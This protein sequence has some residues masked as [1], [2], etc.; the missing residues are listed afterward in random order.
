MA[1]DADRAQKDT[2][3]LERMQVAEIHR[4]A[5][6]MPKGTPGICKLCGEDMPR[7]VNGVCAPCRDLHK[8]P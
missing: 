1:D 5:A 8:L 4:R 7:L 6:E 2:E 3:M